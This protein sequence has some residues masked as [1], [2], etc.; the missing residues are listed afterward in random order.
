MSAEQ[1]DVL[2]T[3]SPVERRRFM[4][5]RDDDVKEASKMLS[6]HLAWREANL[7]RPPPPAGRPEWSH[8][9]GRAIDGTRVLHTTP[10]MCDLKA[11]TAEE[12][13][14]DFAQ[15]I[16]SELDRSSDEMITILMDTRGGTGWPNPPAPQFVTL[17]RL[18]AKVL[19][20]NFPERLAKLCIYPVPSILTFV[21]AMIKPFI[22]AKSV[23]KIGVLT[24][25][26]KRTTDDKLTCPTGLDEI[27]RYECFRADQAARHSDMQKRETEGKAAEA[28]GK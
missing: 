11:A 23:G 6:N 2:S 27:V 18:G 28:E 25:A 10:A 4:T 21:Y 9:H 26:S 13:L 19:S 15:T 14:L 17:A 3:V 7:P 12:Y 5:A 20:D 22:P 8:W 1:D 16:D 24:G